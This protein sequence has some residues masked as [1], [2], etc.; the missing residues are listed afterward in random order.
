MKRAAPRLNFAVL[1]SRREN[2]IRELRN[3]CVAANNFCN[4]AHHEPSE[5]S[6]L[7]GNAFWSS[8]NRARSTLNPV[9]QSTGQSQE[10]SGPHADQIKDSLH[11]ILQ[12]MPAEWRG[13]TFNNSNLLGRHGFGQRLDDL[14]SAKAAAG[15]RILKKDLLG[16]GY[17]EDYLRVASNI[18]TLLELVLARERD[19]DITQVLSFASEALPIFS[20]CMSSDLPVKLYLGQGKAPFTLGHRTLLKKFGIKLEC[21]PSCRIQPPAS[22]EVVVCLDDA[23]LQTCPPDAV[24]SSGIL[25]IMN[26]KKID[27][28]SILL[29]RK[30]MSTPMTTPVAEGMLQ[31]LAGLSVTSNIYGPGPDSPGSM[32]FYGHLQ[33]LCGTP[34]DK[35]ANPVVSTVGLGILSSLWTTLVT[36]GGA[37]VLMCSTAYGGSGQLT[38]IF[39]RFGGR[40]RKHDF[41][42][43][44][45]EATIVDSVEGELSTLAERS[46]LLPTTVIFLEM[47]TN[48]DMKVADLH[49]LVDAIRK[50]KAAARREVLLLVDTTFAPGSKIMQKFREIDA[51]LSVMVFISLSK[52]ISRGLTTGG[53]IIANHRDETKEI[54]RGVAD[55][56][57]MLD[58]TSK[59]DQMMHLVNHHAQVE[60]RCRQAYR[61][62]A[63]IGEHLQ[64]SVAQATGSDMPLAFVS[65]EQA[66]MGFTTST[67]SFNLPVVPGASDAENDALAQ[68][69]V[70]SLCKYPELFKPCVSF[71]QDNGLVYCTVP[72]TSTQ[73]AVKAEDK[74]KQ[75][76]G[77]VQ[78]ARL[79]FPPTCRLDAVK[80]IIAD[81][82]S[83]MYTK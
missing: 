11:Q 37:D 23:V 51:D 67:F 16:I 10:S 60:E 72:A 70:D 26:P 31:D 2:P 38:G 79:S 69:F 55:A 68:K 40:F 14:I 57:T 21:F 20:I 56:C 24:I 19:L 41:H 46:D 35:S 43:Q 9:E 81:S 39:A 8:L 28:D 77:G 52:S 48:P 13:T 36:R 27:P 34:V 83:A 45:R 32:K 58:L 5:P 7:P 65:P 64:E 71:G 74:M 61:V 47:P 42:I 82:V 4:L 59:P 73:G 80:R 54:L 76:V 62:A 50:Y 44:G 6:S 15:E 18:S 29:M 49:G 66:A 53:T 17:A 33:S 25:Y 1:S 30:R 22:N 78:L 63:D 75:A 12:E 3:R